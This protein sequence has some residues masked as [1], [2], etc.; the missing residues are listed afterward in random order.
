MPPRKFIAMLTNVLAILNMSKLHD[1]PE[2]ERQHAMALRDAFLAQ[3]IRELV[4]DLQ[5]QVSVLACVPAGLLCS[6]IEGRA[7]T[8][9]SSYQSAILIC[10]PSA[11]LKVQSAVAP[12]SSHPS[13]ASLDLIPFLF[14]PGYKPVIAQ[15]SPPLPPKGKLCPRELHC[16]A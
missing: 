2:A 7:C 4:P 8:A 15:A 9:I 3:G 11:G 13:C 1:S 5:M 14:S 10:H 16:P 6:Q 12:G